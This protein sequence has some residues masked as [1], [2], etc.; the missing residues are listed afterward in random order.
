MPA[1]FCALDD[2]KFNMKNF[3]GF[4]AFVLCIGFYRNRLQ[5]NNY[6]IECLLLNE[7]LQEGVKK[8]SIKTNL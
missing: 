4:I 2:D 8:C 1:S 3:N 7:Q 5:N 6:R